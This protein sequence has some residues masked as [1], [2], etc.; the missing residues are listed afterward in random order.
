[1][2]SS[3]AQ[4][5]LSRKVQPLPW[6][7]VSVTYSGQDANKLRGMTHVCGQRLKTFACTIPFYCQLPR[8]IF[9]TIIISW[10]HCVETI[11]KHFLIDSTRAQLSGQLQFIGSTRNQLTGQLRLTISLRNQLSRQFHSTDTR[12]RNQLSGQLKWLPASEIN[13][14]ENYVY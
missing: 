10:K 8:S 1:M 3:S 13:C 7:S 6:D 5:H 9:R 14:P 11:R 4:K 12:R 2:R